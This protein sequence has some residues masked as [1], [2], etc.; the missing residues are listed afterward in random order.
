MKKTSLIVF[1]VLLLAGG[2]VLITSSLAVQSLSN[3]FAHMGRFGYIVYIFIL[4]SAVVY[5]PMTGTPAI[6]IASS[7]FGAFPTAIMSVLGWTLGSAI[8]FYLSRRFGRAFLQKY[9]DLDKID[10]LLLKIPEDSLF[11]FIVILRL[12]L[13]IDIVSYTLGLTKSLSFTR[14]IVATFIG[15]IW[16]SFAFAYMGG[17]II[18]GDHK[19]FIVLAF[20]SLL[21]FGYAVY[22][23]YSKKD[24]KS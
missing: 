5:A 20:F 2:V 3:T 9:F 4:V 11:L 15:V 17:A 23:L 10:T 13:P 22:L 16:F 8:A 7:V 12:T 1:S 24:D 19:T 18:Q 6:L 21:V 14:Y